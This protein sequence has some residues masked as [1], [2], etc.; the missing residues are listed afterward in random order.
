MPDK[1]NKT[2]RYKILAGADGNRYR[3]YCDVSGALV[4]T[5]EPVFLD[6]PEN[7]LEFA[8]KSEGRKYFSLCHRCGRWVSDAMY[9][10]DTLECVECS[11]WEE[12]PSYCPH[13]GT[14]VREGDIFCS[15]CGKRLRYGNRLDE[16][17]P[18]PIAGA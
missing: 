15:R 9:N 16:K 7:E 11:P 10:I 1:A 3:F 4:C 13:C 18:D 12:E 2:A 8:W 5:T 6:T 17:E 14:I